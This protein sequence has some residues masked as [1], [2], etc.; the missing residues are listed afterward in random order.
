M[1][2]ADVNSAQPVAA[3]PAAAPAASASAS[4][5]AAPADEMAEATALFQQ[6]TGGTEAD[7]RAFLAAAG[8]PTQVNAAV[9]TF[10]KT[11]SL[12]QAY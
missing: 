12:F 6:M 5:S 3:A 8:G 7:A 4:A 10:F 11:S 2:D 1:A 9:D